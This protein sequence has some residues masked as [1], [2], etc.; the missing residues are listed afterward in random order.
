MTKS[1]TYRKAAKIV[2]TMFGLPNA[3]K[4]EAHKFPMSNQQ[5]ASELE[6]Y[7]DWLKHANENAVT[8]EYPF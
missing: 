8:D 6:H 5:F 7:Q 2:K 4:L 3:D 1:I